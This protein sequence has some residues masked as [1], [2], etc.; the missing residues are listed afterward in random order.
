MYR[1]ES[2]IFI[3]LTIFNQPLWA[4]GPSLFVFAVCWPLAAQTRIVV[5]TSFSSAFGGV[6]AVELACLLGGLSFSAQLTSAP[7]ALNE[8]TI[9]YCVQPN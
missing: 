5:K 6:G 1:L 8:D 7:P 4:F 2:Q 9:V 3:N